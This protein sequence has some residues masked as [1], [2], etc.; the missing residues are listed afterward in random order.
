MYQLFRTGPLPHRGEASL[1]D[2]RRIRAGLQQNIA[3]VKEFR[4]QNPHGLNGRP[5][6]LVKLLQNLNVPITLDPV[7]YNDKVMDIALNVATALK[8]TTA[9]GY[10]QGFSP[11]VF[12]GPNVTEVI[13]ANIDDWDMTDLAKRWKELEPVRVLYHPKSDLACDV[14]DGTLSSQEAG[15]AV[16]SVNVPMLATQYRMWRE[17]ER[18]LGREVPRSVQQFLMELP[19]PNMLNSHADVAL[20]N[21]LIGLHFGTPFQRVRGRH[22]FHLTDWTAE[23]DQ[24]LRKVLLYWR[25]QNFTFDQMVAQMPTITDRPMHEVLALPELPNLRQTQWAVVIARLA[26]TV[27]L[28]RFSVDN[29]NQANQ[30]YLNY[31]RR[32]FAQMDLWQVMK[33]ALPIARYD[34]VTLLLD[35]GIIAYL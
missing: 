19:L 4:R 10:G 18:R 22:S 5:H 34:D 14:P 13:W 29:Q 32:Y 31:L 27:F 11:G 2:F 7:I 9:V 20:L 6:V 30:N 12:Y 15:M 33:A 26:I 24:N 35:E 28:V 16:I 17:E 23:V 1:P 25:G 3:R 8:M 21:R